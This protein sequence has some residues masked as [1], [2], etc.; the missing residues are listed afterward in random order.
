MKSSDSYFHCPNYQE[1]N[2]TG[3]VFGGQLLR[4]GLESADVA[5]TAHARTRCQ[6]VCM[7]DV[8]FLGLVPLGALLHLTARVVAVRGSL[9]SGGSA[10][11]AGCLTRQSQPGWIGGTGAR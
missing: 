9:V 7:R 4:W 5:A 3:T 2:T 8:P 6:L 11:W 1:R 10:T